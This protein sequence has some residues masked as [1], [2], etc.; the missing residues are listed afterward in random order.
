M[1]W[2]SEEPAPEEPAPAEPAPDE[3]EGGGDE[4]GA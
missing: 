1:R 4:D 3:G 2:E